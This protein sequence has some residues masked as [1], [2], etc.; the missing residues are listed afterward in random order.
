MKLKM[1]RLLKPLSPWIII[2][3]MSLVVTRVYWQGDFPYTHD[4]ENHLIRFT[5]YLA[6]LRER[7]AVPRFAP[8]LLNGY[9]FPVFNYNY[10]LA[11]ILSIP[12]LVL[13]IHPETIFAIQSFTAVMIGSL[14]IYWLLCLKKNTSGLK[15]WAVIAYLSSWYVTSLIFYRG[16]I[17]EIW[18]YALAP[19]LL[20]T[21]LLAFREG[22]IGWWLVNS[23]VAAFLL[24]S[25][26][27]LGLFSVGIVGIVSL[28]NLWQVIQ[29]Q[30]FKYKY[31]IFNWIISW[32]LG[33][34]LT[35]WFWLPAMME[36][37]LVNL[38]QANVVSFAYQ[39]T[40]SLSQLLFS[41]WRFGY[42]SFNGLDTMGFGLGP[43]FV[44]L[45]VLGLV[46]FIQSLLAMLTKLIRFQNEICLPKLK[47]L[48]IIGLIFLNCFLV[49]LITD[50][51]Q[52]LWQNWSLIGIWQFPWRLLM[53]LT[54]GL[55]MAGI[56][57]YQH[58]GWKLKLVLWFL[59]LWQVVL[60]L[61]VQPA[62]RIHYQKE[63]YLLSPLT[64]LTQNENRPTTLQINVFEDWQP[65]PSIIEGSGE[66]V[67]VKKWLGLNR[68]YTILAETDLVIQES[69][70][71]FPGWITKVDNQI[72]EI[73]P[74]LAGGQIAYQLP[75][76][77]N[78]PYQVTTS[79][80]GST[81]ARQ[82][83]EAISC[84]AGVTWLGLAGYYLCQLRL[85]RSS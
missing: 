22:N 19:L 2:L 72:T 79:F 36:L 11:N 35:F 40:L 43:L 81:P 21:Q 26:N 57:F 27:L 20:L 6:A 52:W 23:L 42:S 30:L 41:P 32:L 59:L 60:A 25:H 7:P 37:S 10:P 16:N 34:T 47:L 84:L 29:G 18:A 5:N 64:S 12:L 8:Y 73:K 13:K 31:L 49:Y 62:D 38:A 28:F 75:A 9:G 74:E 44:S 48:I 58:S 14:S 63:H 65:G 82:L 70:V 39:H 46:F 15:W 4:G 55:L 50:S 54:F 85:Q 53:P 83:G 78:E 80:S 33:F 1:W 45:A 51:S 71:Y 3:L 24:L 69:T 66:V 68:S 77:P 17:G 56:Y 61:Q 67:E 76:R